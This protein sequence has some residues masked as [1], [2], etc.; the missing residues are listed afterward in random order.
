[1]KSDVEDILEELEQ[2]KIIRKCFAK[3]VSSAFFLKKKNGEL[4][5]VV[6]YR[7]LNSCTIPKN[8]HHRKFGFMVKI[9]PPLAP[10]MKIFPIFWFREKNNKLIF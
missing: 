10:K 9:S 3:F 6:D 4:R 2:K 8:F 1:M 7:A 5:L